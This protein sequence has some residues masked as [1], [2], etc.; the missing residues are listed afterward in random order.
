[1]T[2]YSTV[3]NKGDIGVLSVSYERA[4]QDLEYNKEKYPDEEWELI[5][6]DG[7]DTEV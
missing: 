6:D 1:M 4:L 5:V 2:T 3:N 7:C